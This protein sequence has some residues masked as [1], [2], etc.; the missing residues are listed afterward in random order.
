VD[1][2]LVVVAEQAGLRDESARIRER[3]EALEARIQV[4]TT[5][6]GSS[7]PVFA[8]AVSGAAPSPGR[9]PVAQPLP[10]PSEMNA[11]LRELAELEPALDTARSIE[12]SFGGSRAESLLEVGLHRFGDRIASVAPGGYRAPNDVWIHI[13]LSAQ[14]PLSALLRNG[15]CRL[16]PEGSLLL[17]S[18]AAGGPPSVEGLDREAIV[19]SVVLPRARIVKWRREAAVSSRVDQRGPTAVVDESNDG[20]ASC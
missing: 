14:W 2:H 6:A 3:V 10:T 20:R 19:R 9:M 4:L 5:Q 1:R 15:P 11:L 16:A 17:V 13:D 8:A 12:L 18:T 7:A